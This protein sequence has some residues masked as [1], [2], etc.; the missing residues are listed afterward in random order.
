MIIWLLWKLLGLETPAVY[1]TVPCPTQNTTGGLPDGGWRSK[2]P[3]RVVTQRTRIQWKF[4]VKHWCFLQLGRIEVGSCSH[5]KRTVPEFV[6][7]RT[8]TTSS[9]RSRSGCFG[10][11]PSAID[12]FTPS[13]TNCTKGVNA[14]GFDSTKLNKAGV[15]TPLVRQQSE[16]H[17]VPKWSF[18]YITVGWSEYTS[19]IYVFIKKHTKRALFNTRQKGQGLKHPLGLMCARACVTT[20]I[21]LCF[22][23]LHHCI[24]QLLTVVFLVLV[25]RRFGARSLQTLMKTIFEAQTKI[26]SL[27]KSRWLTTLW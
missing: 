7:N 20:I 23:H 25:F 4:G 2:T 18:S 3:D 6:W 13:Q 12:V 15:K 8:E 10:P 21:T 11:H 16:K 17:L 24:A 14:P 27:V 26:L 5:H 19:G 1:R 9:T 22:S